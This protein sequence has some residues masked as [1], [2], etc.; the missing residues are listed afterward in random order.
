MIDGP[1]EQPPAAWRV[2]GHEKLAA[3][4]QGLAYGKIARGRWPQLG[5][6]LAPDLPEVEKAA[7]S[8]DQLV[9]GLELHLRIQLNHLNKRNDRAMPEGSAM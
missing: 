1:K 3:V 9:A 6:G 2:V 7:P 4:G 5:V 8:S